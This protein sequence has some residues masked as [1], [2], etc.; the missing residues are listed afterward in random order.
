MDNP[1]AGLEAALQTFYEESRDLLQVMEENL[2]ALADGDADPERVN[3]LFRAAHTIKGSAGMFDLAPVVS[4]T[5]NVET[6]MSQ[7]R[8]GKV[9][10]DGELVQLLLECRDH[11]EDLIACTERQETPAAP[12]VEREQTLVN[13]LHQAVGAPEAAPGPAGAGVGAG[14]DSAAPSASAPGVIP[15][16]VEE[17]SPAGDAPGRDAWHLSLRFKPGVLQNGMDPLGFLRYLSQIGRIAHITTL[18]DAMPDAEQMNPLDCYLGF[19]IEL[20]SEADKATIEHVFDF[21]WSDCQL[22]LLPPR[23]RAQ[24]FVDLIHELPEGPDRLGEILVAAGALT[25]KELELGLAH[26]AKIGNAAEVPLGEILVEQGM[27]QPKV[28]EAALEHQHVAKEKEKRAGENRFVRVH[29]EKLDM[30]INLVGELVIAGATAHLEAKR[31]KDR[32]LMESSYSVSRLVEEIRDVALK[33]RMVEIGDSFNRFHRVVREMSK[34]LDK[35]IALDITGAETEL[36]KT[37][38]EKIGDPLMHL[39]RNSID[40]GLETRAERLAAGKAEQGHIRLNAFHDSGSIVVEVGD[41]GRGLNREKILSRARERGL[42]PEGQDPEDGELY[43][44]IFEPGF[45]TAEKVTNISGRGVGMDVVKREITGLRGNVEIDTEAGKGTTI[46]LRLPLTLAIIDG[47]LVRVGGVPFVLPLEA[48]RECV[49]LQDIGNDR[50]HYTNLRGEVLPYVRLRELFGVEGE[51][52]R[53]ENIVVVHY[54]GRRI[55]VVVD[56]LQG[57][58][59]TVIK[60]LGQLFRHLRGISGSSILG[61]GEVALIVDV[62][63]LAQIA[64]NHEKSVDGSQHNQFAAPASESSKTSLE[65]N[66]PCSAI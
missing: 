58:L 7:V 57:E 41:D 56:E 22:R 59:Q 42:V 40:H 16:A 21:V 24:D 47:F 34:D 33:L 18:P 10:L 53:R 31:R 12:M 2:E 54:L 1:L 35:V 62:S 26:Q 8:D 27:V 28:V 5:H 17:G 66:L 38:V 15:E 52:P 39:V 55:G 61:S 11:L 44:L 32:Q 13:R 4:F 46:R 50:R 30:L 43:A 23:S 36:D 19:E 51:V 25:P 37:V 63:A 65:R 48:V 45:S 3:A 6:L 64:A 20:E 9:S 60:P 14:S 29:A 49:A